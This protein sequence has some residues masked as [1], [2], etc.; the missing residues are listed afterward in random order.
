[1]SEKKGASKFEE[2][3]NASRIKDLYFN[4]NK[5]L[6]DIEKEK[7]SYSVIT[8]LVFYLVYKLITLGIV[9]AQNGFSE[10]ISTTGSISIVIF[11]LITQIIFTLIFLGI[12]FL[13]L[14]LFVKIFK[15]KEFGQTLKIFAYGSLIFLIY[16]FISV[17]LNI[18]FPIDN[19]AI[20]VAA[21]NAEL[22]KEFFSQTGVLISLAL[23]VI[24]GIHF[25]V[26]LTKGIS[27][28]NKFSKLKS[29]LIVIS[30]M[31]V[32]GIVV[33]FVLS[34]I[35]APYIANSAA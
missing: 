22:I 34:V 29:S 5:F 10:V 33:L 28:T 8:F 1:M 32:G 2:L 35:M 11:Q 12:L 21:N 27:K 30:S 13:P 31:I 9:F 15:G 24:G 19:T 25:L 17:I 26:F 7:V 14:Y 18:A 16:S 23:L 3:K 6:K 4:A 20:N